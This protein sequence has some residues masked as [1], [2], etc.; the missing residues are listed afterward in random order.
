[1][2]LSSNKQQNY[3]KFGVFWKNAGNFKQYN[4]LIFF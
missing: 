2:N 1:M 3:N 4:Y